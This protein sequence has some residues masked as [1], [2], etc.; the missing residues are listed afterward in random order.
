MVSNF[1]LPDNEGSR[2]FTYKPLH[3]SDKIWFQLTWDGYE[4]QFRWNEGEKNWNLIQSHPDPGDT[5]EFYNKCGN[6][7]VCSGNDSPKCSC[8]R[9]FKPRHWDQWNNGNWSGGCRRK[10]QLMSQRNSSIGTAENVEEDGFFAVR[11][12][13]LA[14]FRKPGEVNGIGCLV[15]NGDLVDAQYF[16]KGGNTLFI[17]LA[18]SDL[19]DKRK[20]SNIVIIL[21]VLAGVIFLVISIWLIWRFKKKLKVLPI[22]S[23]ASCC[24]D[25]EIPFYDVIK[26]RECSTELSGS[27]ELTEGNQI[28]GPE[29]PLFNFNSILR[30]TNNFSEGNKLGQGGFGPVYKGKL[31]GEQEIAVKRLSGRSGQG[32]QEFKNEIILIAKLQHRNLVRLLGCCIQEEEKMLIYEYMQN[33]SLDYFLFDQTKQALLDWKRRIAI[34]E[35]IARGLLYLHRDSRLRII[36]RDLKASNI[37]LDEDMNPKIS[38]FGLARIF[39]GNQNEAN[40]NHVVGT[41]GYMSPEY[42]MEGLFS[43]KSDVYSFGVLLLEIL[44][45]R[46]NTSFRLSEHS[47]LVGHAWN[48]WSEERAMELIDSSIRNTCSSVEALRCIHIAMLCVQDSAAHRPNMPSV[49]LMLES[50]AISLPAPR[51]PSFTSM[52]NSADREFF[53]DGHEIVSSN[54]F[55]VTVVVGR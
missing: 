46:R 12:V 16:S 53:I 33:K 23:S 19:G 5:C 41:Y 55:T 38:D 26:S 50:E 47:S 42:A 22:V 9:G 32:L 3:S 35:G 25:S 45:G 34:I 13:K 10:T 8:M 1:L 44:S 48:L 20:L 52:R 43:V 27:V 2:Y 17:R 4:K 21:I 49:V 7:G 30:A 31:P 54:D 6:F 37:L 28:S 24:K 11:S 29:L 15:W 14:R 51:Q 18:Y 36:H 40:T 39:G